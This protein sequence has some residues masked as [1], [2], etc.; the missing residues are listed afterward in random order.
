MLVIGDEILSGRTR[1]A[2]AHLLATTIHEIGIELREIR[3]VPDETDVM[4]SAINTMRSQNTYLFTSGGIGPTHD[5]I[6]ADA[7]ALAFNVSIDVRDDARAILGAY[8]KENQQAFTDAR[9]RMARIPDGAILIENPIS[10]APGFQMKNTF[11]MAG[12]PSIFEQMLLNVL[13]RLKAGQPLETA[14]LCIMIGEGDIAKTLTPFAQAH[15]SLK[16]GSYPFHTNGQLGTNI[17]LRGADAEQ[18]VKAKTT[19]ETL[20]NIS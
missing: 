5:D 9:L 17:V 4:I 12:V 7:V 20:L 11:V 16:I 3:V 18:V 15:P 13:G 8:Y 19:L 14:T 1:D 2:N 10:A 6:T